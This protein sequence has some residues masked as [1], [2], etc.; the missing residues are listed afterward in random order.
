MIA[1]ACKLLGAGRDKKSDSIDFG[2]GCILNKKTGDEVKTGET[3]LTLYWNNI[4]DEKVEE[5]KECAQNAYEYSAIK[6][7]TS[8]LIYKEDCRF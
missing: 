3:L 6:P 2:A 8:P 4:S 7:K 1:K 5:A